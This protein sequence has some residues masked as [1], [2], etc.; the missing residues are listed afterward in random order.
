MSRLVFI[1]E[2]GGAELSDGTHWCI[3]YDHLPRTQSWHKGAEI[4]VA[5]QP[6]GCVWPF[7]LV[8][9]QTGESVSASTVSGPSP[10]CRLTYSLG[11][12]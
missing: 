4:A 1:D 10:R 8:C 6:R 7:S 5:L 12:H 11:T 2:E 9:Q 3:A